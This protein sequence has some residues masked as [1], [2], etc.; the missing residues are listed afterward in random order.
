VAVDVLERGEIY[1]F[2]RP[3]VGHD[4]ARGLADVQRLYVS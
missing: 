1:F 3:K 4:R 2:Y